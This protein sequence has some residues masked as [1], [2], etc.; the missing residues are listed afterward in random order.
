M[1]KNGKQNL[2]MCTIVV[3]FACFVR[4]CLFQH[5]RH[6]R[7]EKAFERKLVGIMLSTEKFSLENKQ[8]ENFVV[9]QQE[10]TASETFVGGGFSAKQTKRNRQKMK[11]C[12]M[13]KNFEPFLIFFGLQPTK[14]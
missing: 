11:Q 12:S 1:K 3:F 13:E 2:G 6:F 8:F 5:L 9:V 7:Q 10:Y 14:C 4:I